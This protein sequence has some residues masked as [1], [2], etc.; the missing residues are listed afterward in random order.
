MTVASTTA[1]PTAGA[2]GL[3]T[4]A[5][6]GTVKMLGKGVGK[7]AE[8]LLDDLPNHSGIQVRYRDPTATDRFLVA[9][10]RPPLAP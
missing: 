4:D 3:T 7:A 6:M 5:A 8:A 2:A 10:P 9:P 1:N